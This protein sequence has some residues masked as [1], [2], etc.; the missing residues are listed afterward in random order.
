GSTGAPVVT[1]SPAAPA[2][3]ELP[4]RTWRLTHAQYA[5]SVEALV[6]VAPDLSY[7]APELGNGMF[8]NYSSTNFVRVDLADNYFDTAKAVA[9]S[10]TQQQLAALTDCDL[11]EACVDSFIQSM[12]RRAFRRPATAAE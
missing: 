7:F 10:L 6:G 2:G 4:A 8:V 5:A 12:A 1:Y 11:Q 3:P 9:Q